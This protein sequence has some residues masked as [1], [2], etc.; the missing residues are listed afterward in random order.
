M[1]TLARIDALIAERSLLNHS[2]YTRW[3]AGELPPEA[4]REYATRYYHFESAFPR[5]L[6]AIHTRS[7]NPEVRQ[8]LLDNLWD[9]EAGEENHAELWLRFA[10]GVGANREDVKKGEASPATQAL[11]ETYRRASEGPVAGGVAAIYAY[12]KQVPEIAT[13]KIQGL[14]EHYETND[15][16]TLTFWRVHEALDVQHSGSERATLATLADE[17]PEAAVAETEAALEAWWN[18]LSEIEADTLAVPA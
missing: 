3:V 17:E 2:F 11:V 18:F 12:E 6:S 4:I 5:F 15:D 8:M 10:E 14:R 9:E 1:Q 13:A 16:Y 7:E